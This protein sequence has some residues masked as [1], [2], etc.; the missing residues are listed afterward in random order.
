MTYSTAT[1]TQRP[2]SR[3]G[4]PTT[5]VE[6]TT[7]RRLSTAHAKRASCLSY[8]GISRPTTRNRERHQMIFLCKFLNRHLK[9][10]RLLLILAI[11]VTIAQ[12]GSDLTAALPLKFIPSKINNPGADPS[13]TFPLLNG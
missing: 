2:S 7:T 11:L 9:G 13:C 12:V 5:L 4:T 1:A 10:Y 3:P 6:A 8:T